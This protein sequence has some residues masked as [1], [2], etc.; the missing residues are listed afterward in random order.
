MTRLTMALVVTLAC[1]SSA[2]ASLSTRKDV[3]LD[4]GVPPALRRT[5]VPEVKPVKPAA[6][7]EQEFVIDDDTEIKLDGRACEYKDV[8]GNAGIILVDVAADK[9]TVLKIHFQSKK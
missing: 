4:K 7:E 2:R 9:K 8:P 5:L 6:E 1:L 3:A